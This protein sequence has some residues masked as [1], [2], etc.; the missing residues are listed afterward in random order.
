MASDVDGDGDVDFLI[1][2]PDEEDSLIVLRNGGPVASLLGGGIGG[3]TWGAQSVATSNPV[4]KVIAGGLDDK[5]EDDDWL[6][7]SGTSQALNGGLGNIDQT[8]I[9]T[10]VFCD[11]DF[12]QD[13]NIDVLDLLSLIAVW[14]PCEG[15]QEDLNLDGAVDV[16]DLLLLIAAWGP[17]EL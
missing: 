7:S 11:A 2:A 13:A 6:G 17:C 8:V 4:S 12:N 9:V 16:I 14:G 5:D 1:A 10:N 15:C 3:R